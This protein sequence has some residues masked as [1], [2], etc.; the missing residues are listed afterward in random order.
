[1][2]DSIKALARAAANAAIGRTLSWPEGRLAQDGYEIIIS[3]P[4]ALRDIAGINLAFIERADLRG[5]RAVHLVFDRPQ[6]PGGAE[7]AASLAADHRDLPLSVRFLS[8]AAGRVTRLARSSAVYHGACCLTALAH[9]RSRR[10]ILHDYDLYPVDRDIFTRIAER[11]D[12]TEVCGHEHT[13]FD[14]LTPADNI[15]GT[16]NLGLDLEQLRGRFRPGDCLK[17]RG[18]VGDRYR[19]LDPFTF[20]QSRTPR[21]ALIPG[22]RRVFCH[23][24]NLGST[25]TQL[26]RGDQ[27][28][29]AWRLHYLAYLRYLAGQPDSLRT[30]LSQMTV[31]NGPA[32]TF[33]GYTIDFSATDPTCAGYLREDLKAMELCLYG[34]IQPEIEAF[35]AAFAEFL[36]RYSRFGAEPPVVQTPARA[37]PITAS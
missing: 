1:M 29:I 5:L 15:L 30:L 2:P 7:I 20:I 14:G 37:R 4:W 26:R 36:R 16:W 10:I 21:R 8:P 35:T 25:L 19:R 12:T 31:P 22:P 17:A 3:A 34:R 6:P 13:N 9:A 11:L 33:E 27:P 23:V 24:T 18:V 28:A 32:L